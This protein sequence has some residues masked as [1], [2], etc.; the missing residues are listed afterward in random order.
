MAHWVQ[1][2]KKKNELLEAK[3]KELE[4]KLLQVSQPQRVLDVPQVALHSAPPMEQTTTFSAPVPVD[5]RQLVDDILN[6][7]FGIAI[8]PRADAPL[9]ELIIKVPQKYSNAPKPHWEMYNSD[10][11]VKVLDYAVGASGVR[12]YCERVFKNFDPTVQSLIVSDRVQAQ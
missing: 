2:L 3:I 4:E 8:R 6:R 9:F 12:E 1:E 11:R 7:S 10:E 5:F